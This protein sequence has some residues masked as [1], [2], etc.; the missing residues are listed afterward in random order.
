MTTENTD[1]SGTTT[2][3][4]DTAASQDDT[5][6]KKRSVAELISLGT[7]QGMTD[8]EIQ[9][10]IDFEKNLAEQNGRIEALKQTDIVTMNEILE[11][12]RAAQQHSE[13]VLKSVLTAPLKLA[14]IDTEGV[15]SNGA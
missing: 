6:P 9:S 10:I 13:E 14:T 4:K 2:D 8:E 11:S 15:V 3:A 12:N 1:V 7:Y 5:Q